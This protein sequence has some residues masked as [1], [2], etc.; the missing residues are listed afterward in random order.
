KDSPFFSN[1]FGLVYHAPY[2]SGLDP[3]QRNNRQLTANVTNF[4][5]AAGRHQTK[6]GYEFFRSQRTGGNSQSSTQYVFNTDWKL[7][8][9]GLPAKDSAGHLIPVFDADSTI[10]FYPAVIGATLNI[11]NHSLYVQDHWAINNRWSADIGARFEH[12][13]ALST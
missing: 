13:K 4:W 11:D 10:D 12:V 5:M 1:T 9:A 8:A 2:F 6:A 3:E 7:D